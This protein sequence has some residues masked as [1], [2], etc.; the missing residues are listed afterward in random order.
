[1]PTNNK[2]GIV[3]YFAG[4]YP[5][6]IG[7]LISPDGWRPVERYFTYALDNGCFKKWEPDKFKSMLKK[8]GLCHK[9]LFVC[10][11]DVV[12]DAE[13]TM[14]LWH[15]WKDKIDF[16]LAFIAQDGMEPQDVP[17][18]AFC[19]F[20]GGSTDWKLD[21]AYRFKGICQWFHIGRVNTPDRIRW[22][23]EIGADSIDGTGFFRARDKKYVFFKEWF[24]GRK[25]REI[26][27]GA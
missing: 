4:K 6:R 22:A 9:P 13:A 17:T 16:P 3:H 25:Q 20:V 26:W 23:E 15:E 18:S 11:P 19:C 10:V 2:S 27:E 8:A 5:G 1:M 12:S 14:R 21:N 7:L 24:E